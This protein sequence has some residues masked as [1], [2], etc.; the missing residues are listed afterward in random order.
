MKNYYEIEGDIVK[1]RLDRRDGSHLW[2][3]IDLEDL[4]TIE[5]LGHK[6]CAVYDPKMESFYAMYN[7][8]YTTK[9]LHSLIMDFPFRVDHA[10]HDTLDN[11][12]KNLRKATSQQNG[13]NQKLQTGTSSVYKGVSWHKTTNTWRVQIGIAKKR[14]HLGCYR[15]EIEAAK[16]YDKAA[17]EYF[18]EYALTNF[19][20]DKE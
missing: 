8:G 2:T 3:V 15:S 5:N 4:P 17:R 1:I 7:W 19:K 10:N 20:E 14:I 16:T 13:S 11:R 18:G 6:I 9:K 12:R